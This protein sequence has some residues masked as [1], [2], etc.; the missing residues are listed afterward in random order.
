MIARATAPFNVTI[1][2]HKASKADTAF[3]LAAGETVTIRATYEPASSSLKVGLIDEEGTFQYVTVTGGSINKTI[4]V[5]ANGYYIFGIKNESNAE[6][7]V[8]GFVNY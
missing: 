6:V 4:Q 5:S 8:S 1:A 2:A 3:S 7:K